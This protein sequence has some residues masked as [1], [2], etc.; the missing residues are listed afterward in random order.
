LLH[1]QRRGGALS[2]Y[3]AA[4]AGLND[5]S[6]LEVHGIADLAEAMEK[7]RNLEGAQ[8]V[9][10]LLDDEKK[11]RRAETLDGAASHTPVTAAKPP[12]LFLTLVAEDAKPSSWTHV[13]SAAGIGGRSRGCLE[14]MGHALRY[15]R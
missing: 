12:P 7:G 13:I 14:R 4:L 10:E 5:L 9:L 1:A 11:K 6:D 8:E 2:E 3:K 15:A